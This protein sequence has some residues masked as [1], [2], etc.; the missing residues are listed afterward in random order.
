MNNSIIK[1]FM[2]DL[3]EHAKT[4]FF[5]S[6]TFM[7]SFVK[8]SI[9]LNLDEFFVFIKNLID[10]IISHEKLNSFMRMKSIEQLILLQIISELMDEKLKIKYAKFV[11]NLE[12][13]IIFRKVNYYK[14]LRFVF[15]EDTPILLIKILKYLFNKAN[16]HIDKLGYVSISMLLGFYYII[17]YI[18]HNCDKKR[19]EVIKKFSTNLCSF[20]IQNSKIY[21]ISN[22]TTTFIDYLLKINTNHIYQF[23]YDELYKEFNILLNEMETFDD[24]KIKKNIHKIKKSLYLE[25]IRLRS[26][27]QMKINKR[28][29]I[30]Y[31]LL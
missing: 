10:E 7:R 23:K 14:L 26:A 22:K 8:I 9:Y 13:R 30:T 28:V 11:Y 2:I 1:S 17:P 12:K 24:I 3:Y 31:S 4:K 18:L 29:R 20:K 27:S 5:T 19:L 15:D 16:T 6:S 25:N 21:D